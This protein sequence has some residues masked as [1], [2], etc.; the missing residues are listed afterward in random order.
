MEITGTF[1]FDP[2]D[3]IYRDHF[4]EMP[5]VPGTQIIRAFMEAGSR[6]LEGKRRYTVENFR[7]GQFIPPG[8]YRYRIRQ[9]QDAMT[10]ELFDGNRKVANGRLRI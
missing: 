1:F 9:L 10:C 5:V 3:P 2:A 6:I 4:P 8:E 7:F